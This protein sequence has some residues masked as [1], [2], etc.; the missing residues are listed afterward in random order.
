MASLEAAY[1]AISE[2][3][4]LASQHKL[5]T[6]SVAAS[7]AAVHDVNKR[8]AA[9]G[10][11]LR[12]YVT[13][14]HVTYSAMVP[15]L[16]SLDAAG[17]PSAVDRTLQLGTKSINSADQF[18]ERVT[19]ITQEMKKT[20][21]DAAAA[22]AHM[23]DGSAVAAQLVSDIVTAAQRVEAAET[24]KASAL[25]DIENLEPR[26]AEM[27]AAL[28]MLH[29]RNDVTKGREQTAVYAASVEQAALEKQQSLEAHLSQRYHMEKTVLDEAQ[30]AAVQ[31]SQDRAAATEA[32]RGRLASVKAAMNKAEMALADQRKEVDSVKADVFELEGALAQARTEVASMQH[33]NTL[34][35]SSVKAL[36]E[37]AT[38]LKVMLD[39]EA[40]KLHAA[41]ARFGP[42]DRLV[43]KHRDVVASNVS[44]AEQLEIARR[45]VA[46]R[47]AEVEQLV[48]RERELKAAAESIEQQVGTAQTAVS[49]MRSRVV[50]IPLSKLRGDMLTL[51]DGVTTLEL[52]AAAVSARVSELADTS[53]QNAAVAAKVEEMEA[54]VHALRV[55]SDTSGAEL[56]SAQAE[57]SAL[58]EKLAHVEMSVSDAQ[59]HSKQRI[60]EAEQQVKARREEEAAALEALLTSAEAA[61]TSAVQELQLQQEELVESAAAL[62][63]LQAKLVDADIVTKVVAAPPSTRGGATAVQAAAGGRGEATV[64]S[65]SRVQPATAVIAGATRMAAAAPTLPPSS[66]KD[67]GRGRSAAKSRRA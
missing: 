39:V 44:L 35:E 31:R 32:A 57:V 1:S 47:Q 18:V 28:E 37:E 33:K 12:G 61:H 40:A 49:R 19:P 63:A 11:A 67:G 15:A 22:L 45:D 55:T 26:V 20:G 3:D 52:D 30:A 65:K 9:A 50:H 38:G 7:S 16:V 21:E 24:S 53:A 2:L 62:A 36:E 6:E 60:A 54:A 8:I 23:R 34:L 14:Y 46:T 42:A 17:A 25:K 29:A 66:T 58:K 27:T 4:T 10:D 59:K 43:E 5:L 41:V 64:A 48:A 13:D 51:E 56:A